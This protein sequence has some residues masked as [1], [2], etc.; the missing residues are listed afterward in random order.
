MGFRVWGLGVS[1]FRGQGEEVRVEGAK[2][3][4]F[5]A[6]PQVVKPSLRVDLEKP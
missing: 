4:S 5:R 1:E 3:G 6:T 2:G